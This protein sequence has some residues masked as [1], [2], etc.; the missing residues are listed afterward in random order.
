MDI[1]SLLGLEW[2]YDKVEGRFGQVA[3]WLVTIVLTVAVLG[4][5]VAVLMAV[6]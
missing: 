1:V 6:L 4:A 3:A 2:L 5:I